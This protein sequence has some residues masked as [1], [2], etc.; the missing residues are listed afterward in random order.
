MHSTSAAMVKAVESCVV[1]GADVVRSIIGVGV[2]GF[3]IGTSPAQRTPVTSAVSISVAIK[4]AEMHTI[5][6]AMV[7]TVESC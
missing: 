2:T 6:S 7:A 5:W 3:V 4:G 1:A